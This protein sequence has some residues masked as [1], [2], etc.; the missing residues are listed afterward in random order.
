MTQ[1]EQNQY[2]WMRAAAHSFHSASVLL[3]DGTNILASKVLEKGVDIRSSLISSALLYALSSEISLKTLAKREGIRIEKQHDLKNLFDLLP[4]ETKNR[5]KES[6]E[7]YDENFDTLLEANKKTFIEWR[8][9]YEK[10]NLNVDLDFVRKFS[11]AANNE[12]NNLK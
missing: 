9:F 4:E 2:D 5:I 6:V 8:Y 12:C 3:Q 10:D 7:G 11:L 1:E